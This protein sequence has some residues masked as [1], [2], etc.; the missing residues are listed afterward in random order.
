MKSR[1]LIASLLGC[2]VMAFAQKAQLPGVSVTK[3]KAA[4]ANAEAGVTNEGPR[5]TIWTD[6]FSN[7]SNWV[8]SNEVGN[9]DNWVIGTNGPAGTQFG[10]PDIASTTA[11]NGFALFDSDILCS[12]N[13]IANLTTANG[14]D[15]SGFTEVALRFQQ[16]YRRFR[17]STFV[18]VSNDDGA[19]WVK[20]PVNVPL[21]NND[22]VASNPD[23]AAINIT[24]TAAGQANV[25]I[26]FQFYSPSTLGA[27]SGCAYSWMVDDVEL[28]V[29]PVNELRIT[30]MY[31]ADIIADFEQGT[32]P[33]SQADTVFAGFTVKSEGSA[34]QNA[35]VNWS[36]KRSGA[37]VASGTA[38]TPVTVGSFE[39]V[40]AFLSTNYVPD[41]TGSY[42]V[43]VS[44]VG[45]DNDPTPDNNSGVKAF[46]ISDNLFASVNGLANVGTVSYSGA[47][48]V[49]DA[50][51]AGQQYLIKAPQTLYNIDF[52]VSGGSTPAA[53]NVELQ[54]ELFDNTL[55][56]PLALEAYNISASHPT[57]ATWV[58]SALSTP[59]DLAPGVYIASIGNLDSDKRFTFFAEDGDDDTGTLM[60]GPF[61]V[62]GA[63]DWFIGYDFSPAVALNFENTIGFESIEN[64][65]NLNVFP[66][67]AN[68]SI[69]VTATFGKVSTMRLSLV[70]LSGKEVYFK[71]I[72]GNVA[73]FK[74]VIALDEFA[75]GIY[76]LR[77]ESSKGISTQK[78][79]VAH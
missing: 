54:V 62:G 1:F 79:V 53:Q 34:V 3:N 47:G 58:S 50:Y 35:T 71:S 63:V 22:F 68:E 33:L 52:A 59:V 66:N 13:Q 42:T 27:G 45:G 65:N 21:T 14:V 70:D 78:V 72:S 40:T 15:C 23:V 18:F 64:V 77:L 69:T 61:G 28:Y 6:D 30:A 39:T 4:F 12:G 55:A 32:T 46:T 9:N 5:Q 49:F 44:L 38:P 8:I 26:R 75:N 43:E 74:D 16:Q 56:T 10:I 60:N 24:P 76:T 37:T 51:K 36:V 29:P 19:T 25:K 48:P 17:D 31:H 2:T 41:Q 7:A 57:T 73:A 11:S 67:P 20:Y